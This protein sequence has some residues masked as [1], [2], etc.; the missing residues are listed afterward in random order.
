MDEVYEFL[1][2]VKTYFIATVDG[3]QPHVRA[4]GTIDLF[5]GKLYIQTGKSKPVAQ[6]IVANPKVEL[7]GFDGAAEWLRVTTILVE[8][9]RIEA[10]EHMLAGYPELASMYQPGDGNNTVFFL[11]DTTATF[12]TFGSEPRTVTF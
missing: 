4:F 6:Q 11:K 8:D 10:Q 3:D 9:P 2:K 7:C 12:T 1:K 5:E